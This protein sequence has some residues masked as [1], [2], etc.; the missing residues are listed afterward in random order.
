MPF[1]SITIALS[2][3]HIIKSFFLT[4][5]LFITCSSSCFSRLITIIEFE[6]L[7]SLFHYPFC[8]FCALISCVFFP[9]LFYTLLFLF[10]WEVEEAA[11]WNLTSY[12][13][14]Q[15]LSQTGSLC[16]DLTTIPPP[17][18]LT[19]QR[20]SALCPQGDCFILTRLAVWTRAH[21]LM[22]ARFDSL[23]GAKDFIF[24]RTFQID[25]KHPST[26]VC[27]YNM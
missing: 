21:T 13:R 23:E 25:E 3:F 7:H 1:I 15:I 22:D 4:R 19:H 9:I 2:L 16:N 5:P 8:C 17:H 6:R 11:F 10:Q 27:K 18:T 12:N 26:Q 20:A 14:R 24:L